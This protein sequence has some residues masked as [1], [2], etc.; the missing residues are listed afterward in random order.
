[1]TKLKV[2]FLCT[3]NSCRSQM[4]EGWA[5]SLAGDWMEAY[6][7]G[8]KPQGLNPLAVKVMA[9]AGVDISMQLSKHIDQLKHI[10]FDWVITVCDHA[11]ERCPV[12]P[13][14]VQHLHISFDDPPALAKHAKT[15]EETLTHYRRVCCEIKSCVQTLHN[16]ISK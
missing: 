8:I 6:S 12:F 7:A 1:M 13:N 3:G 16:K 15:E 10:H 9:Q 4:A 5:G 14:T 2:L 11:Q